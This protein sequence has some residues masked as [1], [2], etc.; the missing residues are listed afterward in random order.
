MQSLELRRFS[1][2]AV[3]Q[4]DLVRPCSA[5][6]GRVRR[7]TGAL[8]E[9]GSKAPRARRNAAGWSA[10]RRRAERASRL[11]WTVGERT[12]G[13]AFGGEEARSPVACAWVC[14]TVRTKAA[15]LHIQSDQ[16]MKDLPRFIRP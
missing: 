1:A 3:Q 7:L 14:M 2:A 11:G 5:R 4:A 8:M 15:Q 10:P 16:K 13:G 9:E 12:A 6:T